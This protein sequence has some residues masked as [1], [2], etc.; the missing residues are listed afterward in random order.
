MFTM[1]P[2]SIKTVHLL[3]FTERI[4]TTSAGDQYNVV[5]LTSR[6]QNFPCPMQTACPQTHTISKSAERDSLKLTVYTCRQPPR[7]QS[8]NQEHYPARVTG[9]IKWPGTAPMEKA[10]GAR[11]C[12]IRTPTNPGESADWMGIWLTTTH[13]MTHYLPPLTI[14][15]SIKK[16]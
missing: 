7:S 5:D 2:L 4:A 14:G 11:L 1:Q 6:T 15:M 16:G 8:L 13:A 9:T 3:Y 12:P 10:P